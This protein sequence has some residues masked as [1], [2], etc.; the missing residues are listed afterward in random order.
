MLQVKG[1]YRNPIDGEFGPATQRAIMNFQG[2]RNLVQD[3]VVGVETWQALL[4]P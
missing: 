1:F 2:E 3:G 4:K